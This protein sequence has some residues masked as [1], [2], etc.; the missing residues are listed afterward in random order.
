MNALTSVGPIAVG[1]S[2]ANGFQQYSSGVMD[3]STAC[4]S[5]INHVVLLVGYGV[6]AQTG[7]PYWLAKNSWGLTW[8]EL[9][10]FRLNRKTL[11]SCQINQLAASV[12]VS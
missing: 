2:A 8:G 7:L 3:P 6:D 1:I 9:G 4:G 10:Y 12:V 5:V 11:N